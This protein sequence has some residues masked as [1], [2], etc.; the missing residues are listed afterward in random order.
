MPSN[1][2]GRTCSPFGIAMLVCINAAGSAASASDIS[3]KS[4]A[5]SRYGTHPISA[6]SH[7]EIFSH[8]LI[9]G[10]S[11]GDRSRDESILKTAYT[12]IEDDVNNSSDTPK[13][14]G[15][16]TSLQGIEGVRSV[17]HQ[18]RTTD[19]S[20]HLVWIINLHE[21]DAN[22]QHPTGNKHESAH[23]RLTYKLYGGLGLYSD[24]HPFFNNWTAFNKGSPIAPGPDTGN[25]V[26]FADMYLEPSLAASLSVQPGLDIYGEASVLA[27]GTQG[28][29]IYQKNDRFHTA[30]EKSYLGLKWNAGKNRNVNFSFGR[31]NYTLNDGFMIHHVKGS[32]NVGH[33]RALFLGARTAH[34]MATQI[35]IDVDK[36]S[37]KAFYLNPNE[38]ETLESNSRFT[39]VNIRYSFNDDVSVD[40]SHISNIQSNTSFGLP[41]GGT[42]PRKGIRTTG[43]HLKW[44]N[45]IGQ[46]N[47]HFE[48]E[49]AHQRS[50][51]AD[52]SAFAGY[53]AVGYRNRT[54]PWTPAFVVRYAMWSGDDPTTS[55]YERWDPLLPAGSDE[56]MGGMIF[57]KYVANSN[58][59]Q[60]R[61]RLF[62]QP[63]QNLN[64]TLDWFKYIAMQRNNIGAN[65]VLSQLQSRDLGQELMLTA[66]WHVSKHHYVQFVAAKNWPGQAIRMALPNGAKPWT[67]LQASLYWFY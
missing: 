49:I 33:R 51:K 22:P 48:S 14:A 15:L 61:L 28:Q 8:S 12:L 57:S 17:E 47:W 37:I 1:I 27:S 16:F 2:T 50:A 13:L 52:M 5:Y 26:S 39:G 56:W 30:P 45:F 62:A 63:Y 3:Q 18:V 38:Y 21:V 65:R 6:T 11:S 42:I 9:I 58:L 59:Q 53:G 19:G 29:D 41:N 66:R 35:N 43:L 7:S 67:T 40:T 60:L 54:L 25:R 24:G 20:S 23:P 46:K 4:H 32:T 10:E 31:Q 36:W 55:R 64:F 34:D 44:K